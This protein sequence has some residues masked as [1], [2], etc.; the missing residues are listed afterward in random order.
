VFERRRPVERPPTDE[1]IEIR[2]GGL[3]VFDARR[4]HPRG[5][6]RNYVEFHTAGRAHLVRG[7]LASWESRLVAQGFIRVHRSRL[8]NR[9]RIASLKPTS[10]GDLEI[11]LS[12]GRTVLGSRRYR[13]VL[14]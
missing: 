9:A 5:S 12:D 2:D 4:H 7:T 11:T 1:R 14:A 10:S 3:G 13:A 6:R 8:V